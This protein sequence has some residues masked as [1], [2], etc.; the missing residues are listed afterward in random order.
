MKAV[1]VK[2]PP[3]HR[4]SEISRRF[5]RRAGG[6]GALLLLGGILLG[7]GAPAQTPSGRVRG[8]FQVPFFNAENRR[9]SLLSGS[10]AILRGGGEV[11]LAAVHVE[12]YD[13]AGRTNLHVY[14]TNCVFNPNTQ[15]ARSTNALR[16]VSGDGRLELT[17]LGFTWWQTNNT[18]LV[19]N[20]VRTRLQRFPEGTNAPMRIRGDSLRARLDA[21]VVEFLGHVQ[22]RDPEVE[23]DC[24]R[25]AVR[26][27]AQGE[28]DHIEA[29]GKVRLRDL[30]NGGHITAEQ[31][32]YYL[33]PTNEWVEFLGHPRWTAGP[34]SAAAQRFI[35]DRRRH[36][37]VAVGDARIVLPRSPG[38]LTGLLAPAASDTVAPARTNRLVELRAGQVTLQLPPT[39]G[40]VREV[41][42]ITNV[43]IRLPGEGAE[44]RA[45][46]AVYRPDGRIRLEGNP[47]WTWGTRSGAGD[48]IEFHTNG[49][50]RIEG[51]ARLRFP[52]NTLPDAA[53][54]PAGGGFTNVF[55]EIRSDHVNFRDGV[56][57]FGDAVRGRC[58]EGDTLLGT[59]R[60]DALEVIYHDRVEAV[61]AVGHVWAEQQ[62]RLDARGRRIG[63][64]LA[65]ERVTARLG[66]NG[67]LREVEAAG[68]VAATQSEQAP[69][70]PRPVV[71]RLHCETAR[72]WLAADT[73]RVDRFT[74]TGGVRITREG[75]LIWGERADY[76][77]ADGWLRLT[78]A[79]LV[80]LPEGRVLGARE[81]AWHPATGRFR[82]RGRFHTCW[83]Q[84]ALRAR[85]LR[86]ESLAA[87]KKP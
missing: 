50:F 86:L 36:R 29:T 74:A 66:D 19:S 11:F 30:R 85:R 52:L 49:T 24:D 17:G 57:R 70:Q 41:V 61:S 71:T 69:D 82:G 1:F 9:I 55:V 56:I 34:R 13:N 67:R 78:G 47:S 43:L 22:T 65:A 73:N 5:R 75:R 81:L 53:A 40:P 51:H 83:D 76:T 72:A 18:L 25:L 12:S 45:Q 2:H 77:A 7:A 64:T 37:V 79:P 62:P 80:L 32:L 3:P 26:R 8:R 39:N 14:G 28:L 16:L 27:N 58:T 84:A 87:P 63:R 15:V 33:T 59:M 21:R 35:L 4:P 54:V 60:G 46:R 23:L 68:R 42:A 6:A 48:L 10:Q 44:T 31:A 38:S 20:A